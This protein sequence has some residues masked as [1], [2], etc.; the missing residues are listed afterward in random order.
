MKKRSR[1]ASSRWMVITI[2]AM[3]GA[4]IL[5]WKFASPETFA[6]VAMAGIGMGQW[7]NNNE[8]R[9]DPGDAP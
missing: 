2:L 7:R 5:A 1:W 9:F 6:G 4:F 8:G 3:V